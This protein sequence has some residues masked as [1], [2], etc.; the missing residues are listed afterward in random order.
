[1]AGN[2]SRNDNDAN[3]NVANENDDN[4]N[5]DN[6][7]ENNDGEND[8]GENNRPVKNKWIFGLCEKMDD[9]NVEVR[10]FSVA[11][12][13]A[14]TLLP[15]IQKHVN[16]GTEIHSDEWPAYNKLASLGYVHRTVNH[17]E[18]FINPQNGANTQRIEAMWGHLKTQFMRNHKK[19]N[20]ALFES[21]LAEMWWRSKYGNNGM[22]ETFKNMLIQISEKFPISD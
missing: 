5:D 15:I 18:N 8:D 7:G 17:S 10:V 20:T 12:R 9:D 14:D 16:V 4:E 11:K 22:P 19:T 21:H 1:M 6:D 13:D 3:E 2:I